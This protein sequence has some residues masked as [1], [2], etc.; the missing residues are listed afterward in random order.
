MY[1]KLKHTLG[2]DGKKEMAETAFSC[3]CR[4]NV[5]RAGEFDE[6]VRLSNA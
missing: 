5:D 4:V 1:T 2:E 3:A 6:A